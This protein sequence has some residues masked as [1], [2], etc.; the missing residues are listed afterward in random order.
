MSRNGMRLI[1]PY[2]ATL[3][4]VFQ[5]GLGNPDFAKSPATP[6]TKVSKES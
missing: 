5:I 4:E 2:P 1:P 3:Q 6:E